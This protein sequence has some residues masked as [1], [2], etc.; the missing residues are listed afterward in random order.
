MSLDSSK[1]PHAVIPLF[2][3][4]DEWGIDDDYD[5]EIKVS[6]ATNEELHGL[7]TSLDQIDEDVLYEWLEGPESYN[8]NLSREYVAFTCFTMA[9][10]SAKVQLKKR[11]IEPNSA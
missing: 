4:V 10:D 5:R 2:P 6:A 7:L 11:G 8:A 1:V 3:F 9:I